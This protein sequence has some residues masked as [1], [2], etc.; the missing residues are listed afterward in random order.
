MA[1]A[2]TAQIL[3]TIKEWVL[4]KLSEVW[5][6]IPSQASAQNQLADKAF[7]N[8]S[9]ATATATFRGTY[10]LVSDLSLTTSATQQQIAAALA[11]KMAA[12]SITPDT[13]DYA[14]VQV[15]AADATPTVIARVDRYKFNGTAW[16]YEY[17]LNNSGFTAAQWAAINSGITAD[18]WATTPEAVPDSESQEEF[19]DVYQSALQQLY[20]GITDAQN[21]KADYVGDDNYVYRWNATA[22]QYQRTNLYVKGDP[23]VTD[24]TQ[25][26][27][28]PTKLS[29]FQDDLGTHP[30]HTHQQYAE[31]SEM[32][33]TPGTGANADKTTI[34][35]KNGMTATVLVSHQSQ[36]SLVDSGS[37]N[38]TTK[39]IELKHGS[40]V[41]SEIDATA[42]I[43]DGMV[44]D[45]AITD[46]NLVITFNTDA[47]KQ[48][49]SIPLTDIFNPANY[50][51][52]TAI[53]SQMAQ[54]ANTSDLSNCETVVV[55]EGGTW[56]F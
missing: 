47:G 3:T 32:A 27:N 25:L 4:G 9:I 6:L 54:K 5:A 2:T 34:Q 45:V 33:V 50:Y 38:S 56:P 28:K 35:L 17:S 16:A 29:Q 20:Q 12:L 46:G 26:E 41:F 43:K 13:N 39:K 51:D 7:V 1:K 22:G 23:G 53:D 15:P 18:T 55:P 19:I 48:P 37:Y 31:K 30:D 36:A 44:S 40:T 8:S 11:T 24:Y 10:N 14:F 21:A 42:F 49:I 52:K